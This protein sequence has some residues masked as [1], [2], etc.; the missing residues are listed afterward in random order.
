MADVKRLVLG[1][2][3]QLAYDFVYTLD[4]FLFA[5]LLSLDDKMSVKVEIEYRP[6]VQ[7]VGYDHAGAADSAAAVKVGQVAGRI[8]SVYIAFDLLKLHLALVGAAAAD[9]R[10]EGQAFRNLPMQGL[11]R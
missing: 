10:Q 5:A 6:D 7:C 2:D 4:G 9:R 8:V 3:A 1:I 11:S